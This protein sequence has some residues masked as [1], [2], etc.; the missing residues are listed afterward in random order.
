[1]KLIEDIIRFRV[2]QERERLEAKAPRKPTSTWSVLPAPAQ[3]ALAKEKIKTVKQLARW[4]KNE[5]LSLHGMGPGSIP[6]LVKILEEHGLELK[7]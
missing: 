3:R 6:K 1:M 5:L 4:S 2:R 7:H